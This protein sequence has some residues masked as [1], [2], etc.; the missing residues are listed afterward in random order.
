MTARVGMPVL[1]GDLILR[2][3][4]AHGQLRASLIEHVLRSVVG[5]LDSGVI[6]EDPRL[7][8]APLQSLQVCQQL[9][10]TPAHD[11]INEVLTA[12]PRE[13]M[14]PHFATLVGLLGLLLMDLN[15][16]EGQRAR[17]SE[18]RARGLRGAFLMTDAGGSTLESWRSHVVAEVDRHRL[19]LDKRWAMSAC[20]MR[21]AT[22]MVRKAGSL[23]PIAYLLS[24][25]A[26]ARLRHGRQGAPFVGGTVQLGWVAGETDATADDILKAGGQLGVSRF[27]CQARARFVLGVMRHV[28]WLSRNGRIVGAHRE[29]DNFTQLEDIAAHIVDERTF[30][31]YSID[32]VLALKFC[33][34]EMLLSLV[35]TGAVPD[36]SDA[37]DLL[38]FT[39]MEGSSYHCFSEL[40]GRA[41][42][43]RGD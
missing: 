14:V 39:K 22:V 6:I 37:R 8:F 18:W 23:T 13:G 29:L 26:C 11:E 9:E 7:P 32:E 27:L 30:S 10:R 20:E 17:V 36:Q 42:R 21:F 2:Q 19:S 34:N 1:F 41:A 15:A 4:A 38:G 3:L 31:R 24:P 35:A 12:I 33:V 25:E 16:S 28:R 40:M 43:S 5:L